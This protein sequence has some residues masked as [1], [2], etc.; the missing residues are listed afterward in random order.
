MKY[1]KVIFLLL[2]SAT[3]FS[4]R[5]PKPLDISIPQRKDEIVLSATMTDG[6]TLLVSAGYSIEAITNVSDETTNSTVPKNMLIDSGIVTLTPAGGESITLNKLSAGL[7]GNRNM[8]LREGQQYTLR[9]KDLR[10]GIEATATTILMPQ[11]GRCI[12]TPSYEGVRAGDTL[13][14]LQISVPEA[15]KGAY[16]FASYTTARQLRQNIKLL[17]Q[18]A[19]QNL[20]AFT[21]FEPKQVELLQSNTD[22][23]FEHSFSLRVATTDTLIVQV[24]RIDE[25]YYKYLQAYKRTGYLINQLTGEPINLPTNVQTGYGYFALSKPY[26]YVFDMHKVK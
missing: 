8:H 14:R 1:S 23:Q 12:V 2:T 3:L 11:P 5:K 17:S 15:Q 6:N 10:K 20:S 4:C 18:T 22:G 26:R 7:Y 9:I 13:Y 25:G 16:Y 21:N 19:A 24:A